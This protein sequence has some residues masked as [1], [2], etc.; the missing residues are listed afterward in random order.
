MC[1]IAQ[2]QELGAARGETTTPLAS[3]AFLDYIATFDSI[4]HCFLDEALYHA[5]ATEKTRALIRAIY[6]NATATVRASDSA[7]K[8]ALSEASSIDRG[9]VQGDIVSPYCSILALQLIFLECDDDP[10]HGIILQAGTNRAVRVKAL[11]YADD[12]ATI[13]PDTVQTS[14]RITAIAETPFNRG[15]LEAHTVKSEHMPLM[16]RSFPIINE[17]ATAFVNIN[18]FLPKP[19]SSLLALGVLPHRL[20]SK[21]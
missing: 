11:K 12:I 10:N 15:T 17:I 2:I 21:G 14:K 9:V 4:D 3:I 8:R 20:G 5:G 13:S 18:A 1:G 6:R 16:Q 19:F 7:G